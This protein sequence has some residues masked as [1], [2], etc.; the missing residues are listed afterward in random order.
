[1]R[2][3][4]GSMDFAWSA[5]RVHRCS[6][7]QGKVSVT[8]RVCALVCLLVQV[9]ADCIRYQSKT[10]LYTSPLYDDERS[11]SPFH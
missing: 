8:D 11:Q 2:L 3:S 4:G 7:V 9:I 6:A 5:F 1:M 10:L